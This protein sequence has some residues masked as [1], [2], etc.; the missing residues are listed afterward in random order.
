MLSQARMC[1]RMQIATL[2]MVLWMLGLVSYIAGARKLILHGLVCLWHVVLVCNIPL[3]DIWICF[4]LCKRRWKDQ[5]VPMDTVASKLY[6]MK[7]FGALDAKGEKNASLLS[8]LWP[9]LRTTAAKKSR[10]VFGVRVADN[11]DCAL[12]PPMKLQIKAEK[13]L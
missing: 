11:K 12:T 2:V 3:L 1:V 6:N 7:I 5:E 8:L 4:F 10:K 13:R 9:N